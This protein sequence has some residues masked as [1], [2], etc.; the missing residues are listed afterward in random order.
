LYAYQKP[1]RGGVPSSTTVAIVRFSKSLIRFSGFSSGPVLVGFMP[2]PPPHPLPA[3]SKSAE[4]T[5]T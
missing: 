1:L 3:A 5:Q 4:A 2:P